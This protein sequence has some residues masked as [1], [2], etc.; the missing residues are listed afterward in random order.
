[1]M[2]AR[3]Y[4]APTTITSA[5]ASM[6]IA[7]SMITASQRTCNSPNFDLNSP[8]LAGNSPDFDLSSPDLAGNAPNFNQNSPDLRALLNAKLAEWGYQRMPGRMEK[9]RM[10]ALI[11][12]LCQ[13]RWLTLNELSQLLHRDS[14]TLQDQYLTEMVAT[15]KINLKYPS[16]RNHPQQ[17]YGTEND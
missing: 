4:L 8:N 7:P 1:M 10:Q 9:D 2:Q 3:T 14:K 5:I 12:F 6:L 16:T 15:E 11:A 17:A 13:H